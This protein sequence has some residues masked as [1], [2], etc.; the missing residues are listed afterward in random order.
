MGVKRYIDVVFASHSVKKKNEQRMSL[1]RLLYQCYYFIRI[2][3]FPYSYL[4]Y[5]NSLYRLATFPE[6]QQRICIS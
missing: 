6:P 1:H 3:D 2:H 5:L 4:S